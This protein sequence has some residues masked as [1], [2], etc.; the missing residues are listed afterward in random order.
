MRC[1][2]CKSEFTTQ[3]DDNYYILQTS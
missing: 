3:C 2:T 1:S